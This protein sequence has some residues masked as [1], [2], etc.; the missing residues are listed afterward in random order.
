MVLE[1]N[2]YGMPNAARGW[3]K[4]RDAYILERFNEPGWKCTR[5]RM[6]PC[7]FVIDRYPD[8]A[9]GGQPSGRDTK[10]AE[11]THV[12]ALDGELIPEQE[13]ESVDELPEGTHRSWMLIHTDDCDAYG[14]SN[15]VL[16][17]INDIMNKRWKTEIV[18]SSYVLGVKRTCVQDPEGW[19]VTLSMTSFIDDLY[20]MF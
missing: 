12:H 20:D 11:G 8:S 18:D 17:E 13:I 15:E 19:H 2:L 16:H 9:D 4:H 3:G 1:K 10:S 5:A 7:L 14:T 6:D